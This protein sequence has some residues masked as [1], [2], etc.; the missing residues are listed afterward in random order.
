MLDL[1]VCAY[2]I[3]TYTCIYVYVYIYVDVKI[4]VRVKNTI[5]ITN[6]VSQGHSL[7]NFQKWLQALTLFFPCMQRIA[8]LS[9]FLK[10]L[11]KTKY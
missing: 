5:E 3:L 9:L 4:V 7:L 2:K 1:Q 6:I 8:S 11:G 10:S